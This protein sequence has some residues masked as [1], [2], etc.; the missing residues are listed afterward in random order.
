[1]GVGVGVAV[2]VTVGVAVGDGVGSYVVTA[3]GVAVGV[4]VTVG[5]VVGPAWAAVDPI[6]TASGTIPRVTMTKRRIVAFG[7]ALPLM[8]VA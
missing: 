3:V 6:V 7:T 2:G 5:L 8:C 4:G 1:M